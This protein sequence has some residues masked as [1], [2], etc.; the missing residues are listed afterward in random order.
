MIFLNSPLSGMPR[1]RSALKSLYQLTQAETATGRIKANDV[2]IFFNVLLE[3][4][5]TSES[6][7]GG[8]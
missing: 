2:S 7:G 3:L 6:P 4:E 5:C 8:L 1:A